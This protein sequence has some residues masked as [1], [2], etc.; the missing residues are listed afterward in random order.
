MENP[1]QFSDGKLYK[2][3][4]LLPEVYRRKLY[5]KKGFSSIFEFG[6]R[7]KYGEP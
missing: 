5:E 7:S 3:I 4:G 1:E 2:F 6:A